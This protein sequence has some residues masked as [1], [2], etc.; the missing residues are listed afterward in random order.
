MEIYPRDWITNKKYVTQLQTPI[1]FWPENNIDA[2]LYVMSF[3]RS[4]IGRWGKGR[5]ENIAIFLT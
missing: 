1:F 2:F 5:G 3:P 4:N